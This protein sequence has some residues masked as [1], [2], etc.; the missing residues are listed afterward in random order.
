MDSKASIKI[1]FSVYGSKDYICDMWINYCPDWDGVD[2][3][4]KSFFK[5]SYEEAYDAYQQRVFKNEEKEQVARQEE[6]DRK[7]YQRL[8]Q[9]FEEFK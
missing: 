8:K 3:R 9:K 7:E 6:S 2:E 5:E 4:V 1:T